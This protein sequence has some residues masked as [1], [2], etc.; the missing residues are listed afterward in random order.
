MAIC[1]ITAVATALVPMSP[2]NSIG[3]KAFA[4][5]PIIMVMGPD[6]FQSANA[7]VVAIMTRAPEVAS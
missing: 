2:P 7:P 5:K 6:G 4:A 1:T 3:R